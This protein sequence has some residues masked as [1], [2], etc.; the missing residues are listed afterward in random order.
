MCDRTA[1]CT[2]QGKT[3]VEVKAGE[4]L[5]RGGATGGLRL[6][7]RDAAHFVGNM[8]GTARVKRRELRPA[9][10]CCRRRMSGE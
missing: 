8:K 9:P 10:S 3:G 1:D 4:L 6:G 5:R 7:C 2:R